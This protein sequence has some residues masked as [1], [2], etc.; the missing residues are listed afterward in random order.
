M[1]PILGRKVEKEDIYLHDGWIHVDRVGR[2]GMYFRSEHT[3]ALDYSMKWIVGTN[4]RIPCREDEVKDKIYE[5]F[6]Q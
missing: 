1:N 4:D 3:I 5:L 2:V 6:N